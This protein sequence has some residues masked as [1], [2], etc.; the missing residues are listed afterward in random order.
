LV[1]FFNLLSWGD[2]LFNRYPDQYP[3][4]EL[5]NESGAESAV[6]F[7][8]AFAL[9]A[10]LL[11]READE[12]TLAFLDALPLSRSRVFVTKTG[13]ALGV[14]WLVPLSGFVLRAWLCAS[15]RTSL[16]PQLHWAPLITR[17]CLEAVSVFVYFALGLALS[18]LRRFSLLVLGVFICAYL[19]LREWQV[20]YVPLVNI[21]S[22]IEP[23]FQGRHWLWPT[24]KLAVQLGGGAL[25]LALA[26]GAFTM[27]GDAARRFAERA[28]RRRGAVVIG[29]VAMA[30]TAGLW[31]GLFAYA[32]RHDEEARPG[33]VKYETWRTSRARTARYTLLYPENQAHLV[34]Q[35]LDHADA[36]EGRVRQFLRA[37]PIASIMAD[38]TG[39]AS[40][41]AGVAH[42][43][44]VQVDLTSVAQTNQLAAV[45]AHETTHVYIDH[46]SEDRITD[47]FNST[48]FLHEGL[49]TY[50]EY[51]LFRPAEH[52]ARLRRVAA[53]M[54][55]RREVKFEELIDGETLSR[56]R[57]TDLVYPLG[58]VFFSALIQRYG[59]A[60]V[61]RVVS[62]FARP[63]ARKDLR[64]AELWRDVF[65]AS[66]ANLSE[67]EDAF[68]AELNRAVTEH[69]A[70]IDSLPRLR[71]AVQREEGQIIVRA[72]HQG[73]PAGT[74]IC[75]MRANANTPDRL[76]HYAW[77]QEPGV[78]RV[79][80]SHFPERS[81]W[82]QLGWLV[83]G[84]SQAIYEP[85]VEIVVR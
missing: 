74:I 16:D 15:S 59:E 54:H 34:S 61:A 42:W 56:K 73:S 72:S 51:H 2:V 11:V 32:V 78:F 49:A 84:A 30:L 52:L 83:P 62:A 79:G 76:Y 47:D 14:L 41:T 71:G 81:F 69:R 67:V 6:M 12:G 55:A 40:H 33:T 80:R 28:L 35:F 20:P 60:S 75:R 45:F 1:L 24:A 63:G 5:F 8:L 70:F 22:L 46:E 36:I 27:M 31:L 64:G 9:A 77:A 38:L 48:R 26:F 58:E 82:Y 43:K 65:Q 21:F 37:K 4:E 13:L 23:D 44:Q 17:A 10:G 7:I 50:V 39:S 85:W 29:G 53:A 57:D 3:L 25:C 18:F 66:G 19:M 68:F